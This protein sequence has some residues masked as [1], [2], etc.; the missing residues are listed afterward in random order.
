MFSFISRTCS[1]YLYN[2]TDYAFSI[3]NFNASTFILILSSSYQF[4]HKS[5]LKL[6]FCKTRVKM[7]IVSA[8]LE[9]AKDITKSNSACYFAI[10]VFVRPAVANTQ[11]FKE[12]IHYTL[13]IQLFADPRSKTE[14]TAVTRFHVGFVSFL[15][16]VLE[17]G[18]SHL[19]SC[20]HVLFCSH[21][22]I[23]HVI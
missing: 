11:G 19:L 22:A 16:A 4:C 13:I 7:F 15:V 23:I 21:C 6:A 3:S 2:F 20:T 9:A 8:I 12:I 10:P 17:S 14:K 18:N 5:S 1:Q